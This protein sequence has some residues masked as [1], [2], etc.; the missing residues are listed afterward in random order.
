VPEYRGKVAVV[1]GAA[2]GIGYAV[3]SRAAVGHG[4]GPSGARGGRNPARYVAA[5]HAVT[6]LSET[7][8]RELEEAGSSVG[9]S[10]LCPGALATSIIDS[11]RHWPDRLD[12]AGAA[13]QPMSVGASRRPNS[14]R[15]ASRTSTSS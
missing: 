8:Y 6:A 15:P 1:T 7:L 12:S 2:S 10:V 13:R 5:R 11:A 9:V 4:P 14:H 3:V